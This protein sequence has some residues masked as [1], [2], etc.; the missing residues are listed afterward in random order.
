MVYIYTQNLKFKQNAK[1]KTKENDIRPLQD[2][3]R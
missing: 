3:S 1:F 2:G